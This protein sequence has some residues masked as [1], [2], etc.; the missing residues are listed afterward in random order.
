[1]NPVNP[2]MNIFS[3]KNSHL[4]IACVIKKQR[5]SMFTRSRTRAGS[6]RRLYSAPVCSGR[7]RPSYQEV[8]VAVVAEPTRIPA[9]AAH[10]LS[11]CS[12]ELPPGNGLAGCA[13]RRQVRRGG[14]RKPE[15]GR[16]GEALRAGVWVSAG[17]GGDGENPLEARGLRSATAEQM[18]RGKIGTVNWRYYFSEDEQRA[19]LKQRNFSSVQS[20]KTITIQC[21]TGSKQC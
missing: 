13:P 5:I 14:A 20:R 11:I 17:R 1:M 2:S 8:S 12:S 6:T 21:N 3:S 7:P 19:Q 4:T 9:A 16:G 10:L 15:G 18:G